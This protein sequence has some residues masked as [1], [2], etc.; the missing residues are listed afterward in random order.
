MFWNKNKSENFPKA[1]E[2]DPSLEIDIDVKRSS[3]NHAKFE[4]RYKIYEYQGFSIFF[5]L[6]ELILK[7]C[8]PS[9]K[10]LSKNF[11]NRIPATTWLRKYNIRESLMADFFAGITVGIM[12]IPQ[13]M[14]FALLAALPPVYGL[15]TSFFPS[16]IYWIFGTSRQISMGTLAITSLMAGKLIL[17]LENKYVP[18][19]IKNS[20]NV[21]WDMDTSI[22]LSNDREKAKV[23]IAMACTFWV[24][25]FH[26][27]M[28]FF[29]F[30]FITSYLSEPMLNGFL[31][32]NLKY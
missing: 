7:S 31:S 21:T 8:S 13:G 22:F 28:F 11:F 14:G 25:M 10:C 23:L 4:Q 17:D 3:Y 19:E 2:L 29:Q 12:H 16:L 27:I 1:Y 15:Y 24:G 5:F 32:G 20:T 30:G 18:P 6:R 9:K 26:L